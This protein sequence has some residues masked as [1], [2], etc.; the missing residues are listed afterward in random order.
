[1]KLSELKAE[2]LRVSQKISKEAGV[3]GRRSSRKRAPR[4]AE[5]RGPPRSR[6]SRRYSWSPGSR[7]W[8]ARSVLH[9]GQVV[10]PRSARLTARLDHSRLCDAL[11]GGVCVHICSKKSVIL[12]ECW[13]LWSFVPVSTSCVYGL[14]HHQDSPVRSKST[15]SIG[16]QLQRLQRPL[17]SVLALAFRPLSS[18]SRG[19]QS[20]AVRW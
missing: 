20:S 19:P 4:G 8:S 18:T 9:R 17:G 1:M 15:V 5:P 3:E 16:E 6:E 2:R 10:V 7:S 12:D 13:L 14:E 11:L